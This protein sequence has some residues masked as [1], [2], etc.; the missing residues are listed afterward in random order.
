MKLHYSQTNVMG[1]YHKY[2]FQY[3]MKLHYSQTIRRKKMVDFSFST[4]W[5]YTTL[6]LCCS[7]HTLCRVS[8]P[9]EITLLSNSKYDAIVILRVSVPYE[10]TLLSNSCNWIIFSVFVSVPYEITLL[11]N[12][13]VLWLWLIRVSVPYEITLLSNLK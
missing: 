3:L 6:K 12:L 7:W 11:S 9:Y 8:V 1:V 5:N 4:L 13:M 10:I 2:E